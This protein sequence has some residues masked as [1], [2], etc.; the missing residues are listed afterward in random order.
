MYRHVLALFLL[1][2]G[3]FSTTQQDTA[4]L[5][6]DK[7]TDFFTKSQLIQVLTV[8]GDDVYAQKPNANI[9]EDAKDK[10]MNVVTATQSASF[11]SMYNKLKSDL[12]NEFDSVVNKLSDTI[13]KVAGKV[14]TKLKKKSKKV[15]KSGKSKTDTLDAVWTQ[16]N[17]IAPAK[18]KSTME[19]CQKAI[20]SKQWTIVTTDLAKLIKFD[21]YK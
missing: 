15:A 17:K 19:A 21:L 16:A 6:N 10:V 18:I 3:A 12:G 8:I 5:V 14:C 9:T 4:Q 2:I 20:T 13:Y 1:V 7:L 11:L